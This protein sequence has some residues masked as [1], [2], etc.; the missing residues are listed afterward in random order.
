MVAIKLVLRHEQGV[1]FEELMDEVKCMRRCCL[2]ACPF[3]I[4]MLETNAFVDKTFIYIVMEACVGGEL[5]SRLRCKAP[6]LEADAARWVQMMLAAVEF[7]GQKGIVH[8]DIKPENFLFR[9]AAW[10]S[11][12]VLIDFGL[13]QVITSAT[14]QLSVCCGTVHYVAPEQIAGR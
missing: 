1:T 8:R 10:D 4:K 5:T 9:T 6:I 11:E 3:V 13:S 14:Q 12:L 7:L 2:H